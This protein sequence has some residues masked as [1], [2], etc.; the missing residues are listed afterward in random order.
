MKTNLIKDTLYNCHPQSATKEYA[1][2]AV[3]GLV[4]GLMACGFTFETAIKEL[5]QATREGFS[6]LTEEHVIARLPKCW[7]EEWNKG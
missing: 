2:G 4:S 6:D 7:L 1:K 3:V 5:K